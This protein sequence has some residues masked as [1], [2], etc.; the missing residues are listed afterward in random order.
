MGDVASN[1]SVLEGDDARMSCPVNGRPAA[2]IKW[3]MVGG[4]KP[5]DIIGK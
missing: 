4:N 1:I 3:Y 2:S 5:T